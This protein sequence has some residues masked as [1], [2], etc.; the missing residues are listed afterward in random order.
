[1]CLKKLCLYIIL[2][3]DNLIFSETINFATHAK[4]EKME[5]GAKMSERPTRDDANGG[6]M[7]EK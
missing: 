3:I 1:M 4:G 5:E 6:V 7:E 2:K